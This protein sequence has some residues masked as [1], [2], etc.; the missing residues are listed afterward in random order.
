MPTNSLVIEFY[1]I[2]KIFQLASNPTPRRNRFR[3]STWQLT[4]KF[5]NKKTA[6]NYL[7]LDE[8]GKTTIK[9]AKAKIDTSFRLRRSH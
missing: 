4:T 5:Q 8:T 2:P 9:V 1:L 7:S 6:L 3:L